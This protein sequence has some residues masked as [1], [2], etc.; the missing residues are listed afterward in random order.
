MKEVTFPGF[1]SLPGS[2]VSPPQE[3]APRR[4]RPS[5]REGRGAVGRGG[6]EDGRYM[7]TSVEP[8]VRGA[9]GC[10]SYR[11]SKLPGQEPEGLF[12]TY[13]PRAQREV[14]SISITP[15]KVRLSKPASTE[16]ANAPVSP[17][18]T[19]KIGRAHV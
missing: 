3:Q 15:W 9:G 4:I 2:A 19:R 17:T 18:L 6:R 10:A 13:R 5:R 8:S 14:T 16:G 1:S 7:R 11:E 12:G